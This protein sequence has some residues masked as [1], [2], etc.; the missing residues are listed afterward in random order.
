MLDDVLAFLDER[1]KKPL[2]ITTIDQ[3]QTAMGLP[4]DDDL[5]WRLYEHLE[6][7][8]G[9]LA[10]KVRFGVS[11]ATVTLT[12]QEKLTGRALLLGRSQAQARDL[13]SVKP[14][15]WDA[16]KQML[17]RIGLIS[18]DSWRPAEGHER[19][20]DGVGLLFHTVRTGG[21]VFNVP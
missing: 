2:D 9:R 1:W 20:L 15:Q 8:P 18:A 10:E 12:N 17:I 13:A 7:N 3:A 5:R 11:A 4:H 19:L 14:D 16:T 6:S 21:E